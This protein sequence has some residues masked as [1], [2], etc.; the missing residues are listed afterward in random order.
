MEHCHS[1]LPRWFS[2]SRRKGKRKKF[3]DFAFLNCCIRFLRQNTKKQKLS[4]YSG[5]FIVRNGIICFK[6]CYYS[7]KKVLSRCQFHVFR[8][9][10]IIKN[11]HPRF[12][13]K[14]LKRK[15]NHGGVFAFRIMTLL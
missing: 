2:S 13:I 3:H 14:T 6:I 4:T 5:N 8:F 9:F 12:L 1:C 15:S 7:F 11:L 10:S